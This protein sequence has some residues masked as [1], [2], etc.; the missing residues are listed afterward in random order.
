MKCG[1]CVTAANYYIHV[2]MVIAFNIKMYIYF[3]LPRYFNPKYCGVFLVKW[4]VGCTSETCH[5]SNVITN[6]IVFY[7]FIYRFPVKVLHLSSVHILTCD[8]NF[9]VSIDLSILASDKLFP[10]EMSHEGMVTAEEPIQTL[11][12]CLFRWSNNPLELG[13]YT[14]YSAAISPRSYCYSGLNSQPLSQ[15]LSIVPQSHTAPSLL[16]Q[17]LALHQNTSFTCVLLNPILSSCKRPSSPNRTLDIT[18]IHFLQTQYLTVFFFFFKYKFH[19]STFNS[20]CT[21]SHTTSFI[22]ASAVHSPI[23]SRHMYLFDNSLPQHAILTA[24][25]YFMSKSLHQYILKNL[26]DV[27]KLYLM[28]K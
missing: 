15:K 14:P 22:H 12:H 8:I 19:Q 11:P 5:W 9:G 28:P 18:N 21:S 4:M 27:G 2:H 20:T 26:D 1:K 23:L 3:Q 10:P 16:V 25:P 24:V 6:A 17:P 7:F 13:S